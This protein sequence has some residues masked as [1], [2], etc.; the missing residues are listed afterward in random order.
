ML[1]HNNYWLSVHLHET[2][3]G[4]N[5]LGADNVNK[6]FADCDLTNT[7]HVEPVDAVPPYD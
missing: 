7:A 3:V 5:L 6:W 2:R 4:D 1:E